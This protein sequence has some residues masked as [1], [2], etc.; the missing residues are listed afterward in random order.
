MN[1]DLT[2]G[3]VAAGE[4]VVAGG[5]LYP[6]ISAQ[7]QQH[8]QQPPAHRQTHRSRRK[9][10]STAT[11]TPSMARAVSRQMRISRRRSGR[12]TG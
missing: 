4:R 1:V 3:G 5:A 8:Q 7:Q 2:A 12:Q 10:S 11:R 6:R 9:R